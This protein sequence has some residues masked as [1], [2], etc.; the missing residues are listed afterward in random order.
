MEII[1]PFSQKNA[2]KIVAFG[3]NFSETISEIETVIDN[4]KEDN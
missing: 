4:L 1:K 3:I 2:V